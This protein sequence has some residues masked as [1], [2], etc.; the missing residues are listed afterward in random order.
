[1]FVVPKNKEDENMTKKMIAAVKEY[2]TDENIFTVT[3]ERYR[4]K[5][6]FKRALK[7]AGLVVKHISAADEL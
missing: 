1:M 7:S 5:E 3:S 2:G 4:T 6:E